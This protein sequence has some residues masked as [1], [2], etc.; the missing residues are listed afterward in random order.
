[1][2]ENTGVVQWLLRQA[3]RAAVDAG[4]GV[5]DLWYWQSRLVYTSQVCQVNALSRPHQFV[6]GPHLIITAYSVVY[7]RRSK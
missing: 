5:S 6:R 1:M 7:S 2:R 4:L 3:T